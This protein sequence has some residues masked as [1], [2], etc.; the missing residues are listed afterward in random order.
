MT[1]T[2]TTLTFFDK[3]IEPYI[4]PRPSAM[5][6]FLKTD[7][8]VHVRTMQ[9]SLLMIMFVFNMSMDVLTS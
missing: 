9:V 5:P 6:S 4:D 7:F 2:C 1:T 3:N 8:Y